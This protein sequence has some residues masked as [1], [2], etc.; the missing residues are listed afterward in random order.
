MFER[1]FEF[2]DMDSRIAPQVIIQ[3]REKFID[4]YVTLF[5]N[6][7]E[8]PVLSYL[9]S[10]SDTIDPSLMIHFLN[11]VICLKVSSYLQ[12]RLCRTWRCLL[13]ITSIP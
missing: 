10:K 8:K 7:F 3:Y 11:K 13:I 9:A 4:H 2:K 12:N 1:E 6:H 5:L